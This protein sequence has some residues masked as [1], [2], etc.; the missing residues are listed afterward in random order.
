[1][2]VDGLVGTNGDVVEG[3]VA[4]LVLHL[5]TKLPTVVA[6]ARMVGDLVKAA[7]EDEE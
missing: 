3:D 7:D 5:D 2:I 6:G 4:A 1:V